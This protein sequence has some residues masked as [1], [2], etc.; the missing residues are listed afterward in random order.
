MWTIHL[1]PDAENHYHAPRAENEQVT[2]YGQDD[3]RKYGWGIRDD[4]HSA[5]CSL[6]TWILALWFVALTSHLPVPS[7]I[8]QDNPTTSDTWQETFSILA[9]DP[10]VHI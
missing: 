7:G 6:P 10:E 1:S 8:L 3:S 5:Q 9:V 4:C 2:R